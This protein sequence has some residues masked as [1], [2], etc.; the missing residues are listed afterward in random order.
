MFNKK[1]IVDVAIVLMLINVTDT[2]AESSRGY[3]GN[4]GETIGK[5]PHKIIHSIELRATDQS[6]VSI[7]ST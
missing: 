6:E 4:V 2:K 7:L 5:S 1:F 3:T